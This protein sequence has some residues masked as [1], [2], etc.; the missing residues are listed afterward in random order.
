MALI[1]LVVIKSTVKTILIEN[2]TIVPSLSVR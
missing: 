1:L 2:K